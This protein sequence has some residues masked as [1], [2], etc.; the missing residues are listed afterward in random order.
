MTRR[1]EEK[2]STGFVVWLTG[3][4]GSGKST[5]AAALNHQLESH[6]YPTEILDGD[7]M[8]RQPGF[9]T[10]FSREE[11]IKHLQ[12]VVYICNLLV[13]H[14]VNVIA[15]FVSPY[16]SVG[17]FARSRI[18]YFVEVYVRCSIE[19]CVQRDPKGLYLKAIRGKIR[20]M[21]G[22]GDVYEEP[23]KPEIVVDT[24]ILNPETAVSQILEVLKRMS[25][26]KNT[27]KVPAI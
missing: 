14:K 23:L 6:G 12:R 19:T 17:K 3:L 15:S 8:R 20:N 5:I 22:I 2:E 13:A 10:G 9:D 11:R 4:P 21:T 18:R 16:R 27:S 25:L 26:F 7:E 24:E 1:I